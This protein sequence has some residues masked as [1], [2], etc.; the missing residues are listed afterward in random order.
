VFRNCFAAVPPEAALYKM[1]RACSGVPTPRFPCFC[2][3]CFCCGCAGAR[4]FWHQWLV[5][6]CVQGKDL[7][8]QFVSEYRKVV[9]PLPSVAE[10]AFDESGQEDSSVSGRAS[11]AD[12]ALMLGSRNFATF[13]VN[14]KVRRVC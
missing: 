12:V 7:L 9:G 11:E 13:P 10:T 3:C 1:V 8:K 2:L 14:V 6:V 5:V 4:S